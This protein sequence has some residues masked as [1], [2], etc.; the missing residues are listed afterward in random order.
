MGSLA[1]AFAAVAATTMIATTTTINNNNNARYAHSWSPPPPIN[2]A[3]RQR[4]MHHRRHNDDD[5][6]KKTI[7]DHPSSSSYSYSSGGSGGS[8]RRR[9]TASFAPP[10]IA[11]PRSRIRDDGVSFFVLYSASSSS[12]SD[13]RDDEEVDDEAS[14]MTT[15]TMTTTMMTTPTTD[16]SSYPKIAAAAAVEG[17]G[18]GEDEEEDETVTI[19]RK[20]NE[21]LRESLRLMTMR[22]VRD[23]DGL[24][25]STTRGR[26]RSSRSRSRSRGDERPRLIIED[27]EGEFW[28]G[29]NDDDDA[30]MR[31]DDEDDDYDVEC[32]Y[33]ERTDKWTSGYDDCP[34]EPN[35]DF[36]DA[37]KS[38][39]YW[40][41]GLL[42]LQSCSG[43]ILSRNEMLLM[44]H[45][46]IVYF[47]TMLVGAG[48]NAGNQASVRVIRGLALGTLNPRTRDRYLN[49]EFRMAFALSLILSL[50]GF[51]RALAFRTPL[52]ETLAVTLALCVIVLSS[53]CLGA[54]LPLG[55]QRIGVDPAHSSTTIQV[56][57]D[58]LGVVLTVLVSTIVLDSPW[59]K[60]L[61]DTL[62]HIGV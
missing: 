2:I 35:V 24:S 55:L 21:S 3:R 57:M 42:A 32:V 17:E 61:I 58:I 44:D 56:V 4:R 52:P 31:P 14:T 27:F 19:L 53:V 48:G 12:S 1:N 47:L 22:A 30:T 7:V 59:G 9:T 28:K 13:D 54:I 39:S 60:L 10:P 43:F 33:D 45:P 16:F 49:R 36:V 18:E 29:D 15:T 26:S 38:R 62:S 40:L 37:L 51:V 8:S 20:E 5:A 6:T 46:N 34:V 41:V 11:G 50:A 25:S 23:D